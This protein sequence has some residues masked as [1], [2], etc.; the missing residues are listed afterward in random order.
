MLRKSHT[1]VAL[2]HK[3][4]RDESS[5]KHLNLLILYWIDEPPEHLT[6]KTN[7]N[8]PRKITELQGTENP[9]LQGSQADSSSTPNSKN[10]S[11]KSTWTIDECD[12]LTNF[13]VSAKEAGTSWVTPVNGTL[14]RA[15]YVLSGYL[16]NT[17]TNRRHFGI[18]HLTYYASRDT[19]PRA[20][21]PARCGSSCW[22]S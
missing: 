15:I 20:L 21:P 7:R 12:P 5:I 11:L 14:M 18:L 22:A 4:V 10:T 16:V 2:I 8:I 3:G 17:D 9:L 6:L 1:P 13:E 19:L